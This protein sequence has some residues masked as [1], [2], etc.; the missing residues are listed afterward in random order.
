VEFLKGVS[1]AQMAPSAVIG[2]LK[3][4]DGDLETNWETFRRRFIC[5]RGG[6][7][8]MGANPALMAIAIKDYLDA[9]GRSKAA[10]KRV[11]NFDSAT[12]VWRLELWSIFDECDDACDAFRTLSTPIEVRILDSERPGGAGAALTRLHKL[13]TESEQPWTGCFEFVGDRS[14]VFRVSFCG[15]L[16]AP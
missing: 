12:R 6:V 5:W 9:A 13:S 2:L 11:F 3:Q 14:F 4:T 10:P 7:E 8:D 15:T 1:K 16:E